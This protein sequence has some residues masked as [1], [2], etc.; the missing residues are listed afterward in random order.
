MLEV[1]RE[2]GP[3]THR[4][5][6]RR[7]RPGGENGGRLTLSAPGPWTAI[8]IAAAILGVRE[9]EFRWHVRRLPKDDAGRGHRVETGDA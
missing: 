6:V 1:R 5:E 2:E 4:Y 9:V 7:Q 8:T 3:V